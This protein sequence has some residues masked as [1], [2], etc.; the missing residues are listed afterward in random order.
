MRSVIHR[1]EKHYEATQGRRN[2][3]MALLMKRNK[4]RLVFAS[5]DGHFRVQ[6]DVMQ[7]Q[8]VQSFGWLQ[9]EIRESR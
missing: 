3:V 4:V 1:I 9:N 6:P 7:K 5:V 8:G 2:S